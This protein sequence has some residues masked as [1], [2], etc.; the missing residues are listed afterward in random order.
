MSTVIQNARIVGPRRIEKGSL[1][2]EEGLITA[3]GR[4]RPRKGEEVISADGLIALPGFVDIH[5]HG[6]EGF[7]PVLGM[8]DPKTEKFDTSAE[9]YRKRLP[10]LMKYFARHGVTRALLATFAAPINTLERALGRLAEYADQPTNG[11]DGARLE[12]VFIEGSFIKQ[13][14]CAGAQDPDH[15]VKPAQETFNRLQDAAGGRIRY[16]NVVP[17]YGKAAERFIA[18]LTK[19]GVT[20]GMAHT[21]C[22]ADQ[23]NRCAKAGLRIAQHFLNGSIGSSYKP[24]HGG[25]VVEAVLSNPDIHVELICDGWH[26]NPAYVLDVI[27]RKGIGRVNVVTDATFVANQPGVK[28]FQ[29]G[30][31]KGEVSPTGEYLRVKGTQDTLFGS[32]CTMDQAFENVV[33]WLTSDIEGMWTGRRRPLALDRALVQ[34]ARACSTNPAGMIGLGGRNGAGGLAKGRKADIVL[35]RLDGK[36]GDCR[37]KVKRTFVEGRQVV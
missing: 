32:V 30:G 19:S 28:E 14:E 31:V 15:F 22:P 2:I 16:T 29:V 4:V 21:N 17:E 27:R 36:P 26:V 35:A 3:M 7:E 8:Y 1:R 25:N 6:G 11:R 5:V 34:A 20:V 37:L 9:T 33:N 12:G 23:V 18:W 13:P 24:F 10:R